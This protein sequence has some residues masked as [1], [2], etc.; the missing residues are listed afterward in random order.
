MIRLEYIQ[1]VNHLTDAQKHVFLSPADFV[2][3]LEELPCFS[4][5][6]F[7]GT[8][9]LPV[10]SASTTPEGM[11]FPLLLCKAVSWLP[12]TFR[13]GPSRPPGEQVVDY[14][15]SGQLIMTKHREN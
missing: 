2:V 3:P 14:W 5:Q 6:E 11:F 12:L 9:I 1:V 10:P 4:S 13:F 8:L 15:N 7:R